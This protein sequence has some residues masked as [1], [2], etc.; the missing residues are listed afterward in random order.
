MPYAFSVASTRS[1]VN[2]RWRSRLPVSRWNAFE[3]AAAMNGLP[4]NRDGLGP[5]F[6]GPFVD[7]YAVADDEWLA[8]AMVKKE[9]GKNLPGEAVQAPHGRS[10]ASQGNHGRSTDSP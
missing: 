1:G 8:C 7:A 10:G 6:Q 9:R 2:G 3:I 5:D 4:W